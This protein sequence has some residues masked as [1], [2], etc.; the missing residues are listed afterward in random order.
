MDVNYM[1]KESMFLV[2]QIIEAC[3][4]LSDRTSPFVL[5]VAISDYDKPGYHLRCAAYNRSA[6]LIAGDNMSVT[7][8]LGGQDDF[9]KRHRYFLG[10]LG[11]GRV[12]AA[13]QMFNA[14]EYVRNWMDKGIR[15][16]IENSPFQVSDGSLDQAAHALLNDALNR[17]D[18]DLVFDIALKH[19]LIKPLKNETTV[20][21]VSR[22]V[23]SLFYASSKLS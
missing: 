9:D 11:S 13:G 20:T 18:Q 21:E 3:R 6:N 2:R 5:A 7:I 22:M 1:E 14:I 15:V 4:Y 10:D 16:A 12:F 19:G 23:R 17:N 8:Y